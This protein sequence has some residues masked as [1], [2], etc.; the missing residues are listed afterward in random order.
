MARRKKSYLAASNK[1]KVGEVF[2][3]NFLVSLSEK[4]NNANTAEKTAALA[5]R[6]QASEAKKRAN[7]RLRLEKKQERENKKEL[8]EQERHT[9]YTARAR[10]ACEKFN[11][12]EICCTSM[13]QEAQDAGCTIAQVSS[14]IVKGREDYWHD[15]AIKLHEEEYLTALFLYCEKVV[16]EGRV[17]ERFIDQLFADVVTTRADIFALDTSVSVKTFIEKSNHIRHDVEKRLNSHIDH[18]LS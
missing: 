6:R 8:K 15:K 9:K 16:Q 4:K 11:I 17:L 13:V 7:E 14:Q 12:D 5:A 10:L 2:V 18:H 1:G 3:N